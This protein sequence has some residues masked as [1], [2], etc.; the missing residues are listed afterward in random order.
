MDMNTPRRCKR[1]EHGSMDQVSARFRVRYLDV[2][3]GEQKGNRYA[4]DMISMG[5]FAGPNSLS[6]G[7]W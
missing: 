1:Q 3:K 6:Q 4:R 5:W 7:D 2:T